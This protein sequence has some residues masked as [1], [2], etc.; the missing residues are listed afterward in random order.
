MAKP[1]IDDTEC[2]VLRL[3]ETREPQLE[4]GDIKLDGWT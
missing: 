4:C 1:M 2:M 3:L